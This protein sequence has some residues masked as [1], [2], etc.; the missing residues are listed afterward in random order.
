MTTEYTQLLR[1]AYKEFHHG[2]KYYKGKGREFWVWMKANYPTAFSIHFERAEGGRQDLDYDAAVPLYI[3][4][5]YMV[6]FLHGVVFGADH[7][8]ILEDYLYIAFSSEQFIAMTRA[9]AIIDLLIS[10]P[11][12]WLS[13]RSHEM[14]ACDGTWSPVSMGSALDLV[15]Q[16]FVKAS[17]DGA[18]LLDP[19]LNI[20]STI[21]QK[22]K[23]FAA[24]LEYMYEKDTMVAA[25]GVTKHL[26]YQL[27]REELLSPKDPTNA[28]SRLR[29]IECAPSPCCPTHS[30]RTTW[31][32]CAVSPRG[33]TPCSTT[34]LLRYLEVQ[35]VAGL[36]KM[37][38]PKLAIAKHLTSQDGVAS[39]DNSAQAHTD[40]IGLDATND[41]LA[42]SVFGIYDYVLKRN[43]NI[44]MEAASALAMAMRAK[45]FEEGGYFDTLPPHE[46][47]ALVELAR[48]TVDEMRAVDRADHSEHDAYITAKRK[49]NSQLELDA[50]VKEYALAIT[51]FKQWKRAGVADAASM[52]LALAALANNQ[53]RLDYL[54][55]Q[56]EMRVRGLGFAEFR[57]RMRWSSSK[58]EDVGTV[59]ELTLLL[60]EILM[61]E[62]DLECSDEL[63][64]VAVVPIMKRKT[65]R[66]LGT[67][68]AQAE[69]L[70]DSIKQLAPEE[71]LGLA[72]ERR[73]VL[74]AAGEIDRV[75][76]EQPDE[77][78]ARDDSLVGSM[79]EVCWGRYWRPPTAE[80]IAAGEK[81]K[82]ISEKMWCECEVVLVANGT[83]TKETPENAKCKKLAK[84]GAVRLMWPADLAR[85]EKE[86]FT[87]SILQDEDFAPRKDKH[88]AWR[89][90]ASELKKRSEAATVEAV[91]ARKRR[92]E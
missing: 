43:P 77:P 91:P 5:P 41:R 59:P 63:P 35:C 15:E 87:W 34:L 67:P 13:G 31:H 71:L 4:R 19:Q 12:R 18:V 65:F 8:N 58:E 68:T 3:M 82:K 48:T 79:L 47:M 86:T 25:D 90:S 27:A 52:R 42:E 75:G 16:I 9:N 70:G 55:L 1:A 2:N 7:S 49:S 62:H 29:T 39:F 69:A 26:V 64:D 10:R 61:V 36:R 17:V 73:E 6:E 38:D 51:F 30:A 81:R 23:M 72:I 74:E 80:E 22:E 11:L 76:D 50:L 56:I 53:E 46:Q 28:A 88:M 21:A 84:A 37:H 40:L 20:F 33:L 44:S 32:A 85:E 92:R 57:P 66:E 89:L 83:T 14:G 24:H 78:P 45:S 54:R 60:E